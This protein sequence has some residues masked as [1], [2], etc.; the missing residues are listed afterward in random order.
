[1]KFA[2]A[3]LIA[4]HFWGERGVQ[5]PCHPVAVSGADALM[6]HDAFGNPDA[7]A[8][9][10]GCRVLISSQMPTLRYWNPDLYC[11]FVVHEVGHLAGL[12]HTESGIMAARGPYDDEIPWDCVYW[13]QAA[14]RMGIKVH[15]ARRVP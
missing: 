14:H 10:S 9:T 12:P 13:K 5:V 8:A 3:L 15:D 11:G 6:A 4:V 2:L 1:M 7:M